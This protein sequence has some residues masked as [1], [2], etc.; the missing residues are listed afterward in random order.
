MCLRDWCVKC[1]SCREE[2]EEEEEEEEKNSPPESPES[3]DEASSCSEHPVQGVDL[4]SRVVSPVTP[5]RPNRHKLEAALKEPELGRQISSLSEDSPDSLH[6]QSSAFRSFQSKRKLDRSSRERNVSSPGKLETAGFQHLKITEVVYVSEESL[7]GIDLVNRRKSE[8]FIFIAPESLEFQDYPSPATSKSF[9]IQAE[10]ETTD[11]SEQKRVSEENLLLS[12]VSLESVEPLQD[13]LHVPD[14]T[15]FGVPAIFTEPPPREQQLEVHEILQ[16]DSLGV[17][18]ST[19]EALLEINVDD[20]DLEAVESMPRF[21][22]IRKAMSRKD[23]KYD[24]KRQVKNVHKVEK[25]ESAVTVD[26]KK[27]KNHTKTKHFKKHLHRQQGGEGKNDGVDLTDVLGTVVMLDAG[28][29]AATSVMTEPAP[30]HDSE[31][32]VPETMSHKDAVYSTVPRTVG[33]YQSEHSIAGRSEWD[34]D[35]VSSTSMS[36]SQPRLA[37]GELV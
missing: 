4:Y 15:N 20:V 33:R 27:A 34:P 31:F 5:P 36:S 3:G 28:A 11:I 35:Y 19:H 32:Y 2:E 1:L 7:R 10:A 26:L 9:S 23:K 6:R 16:S 14:L 22:G 25:N 13:I 12:V 17:L 29:G 21:S 24:P 18:Q 30:Q 37:L 8:E